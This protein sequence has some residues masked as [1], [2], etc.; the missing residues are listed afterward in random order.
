MLFFFD[1]QYKKMYRMKDLILI[2]AYCD[3]IDKEDILR[4]LVDDLQSVRESFDIM[5]VSHTTIP[6]D[7][8]RKTNYSLYDEKNEILYD[9]DLLDK[10]WFSPSGTKQILSIFTSGCS[11]HLAAWRLFILGNSLA[12]TLGYKK[13]HHIEYDARIN[14]FK[15]F[16][17]NSNLLDNND[18]ILYT[19]QKENM[20]PILFGSYQA[21]CID[22]LDQTLYILNEDNIKEMIRSSVVRS[23]EGM[24]DQL[25]SINKKVIRKN[26]DILFE[27]NKF[28]L[29]NEIN[30]KK[31]ISWCLPYY[32]EDTKKLCFIIWN[33]EQ[34]EKNVTA[35]IIYNKTVVYNYNVQPDHWYITEIDDYD[36]ADEL[37][38]IFNGKIRNHFNFNEYREEFK[39]VSFR[40]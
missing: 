7:I 14:D 13:V 9:W 10:P 1:K 28:A 6:Q 15:E 27:G 24:L 36:N 2:S 30:Y 12:K 21:Y 29:S 5:L 23:P 35:M 32:D 39:N 38:V 33:M 37:L 17:D 19:F 22:S 25:L 26:T 16:I 18:V 8:S 31:S 40:R 34:K 4:G 3:T 20:S 11:T